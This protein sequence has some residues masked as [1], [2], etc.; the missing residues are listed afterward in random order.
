MTSSLP[1]PTIL[2]PT[3]P[4]T[5]SSDTKHQPFGLKPL[6]HTHTDLAAEGC[7]DVDEWEAGIGPI[8]GDWVDEVRARMLGVR[9]LGVRNA[10]CQM[11]ECLV[12]ECLVYQ[13]RGVSECLVPECLVPEWL[14]PEWPPWL[15]AQLVMDGE[16]QAE[17]THPPPT[18]DIGSGLA[19]L[20][21]VHQAAAGWWGVPGCGGGGRTHRPVARL[22]GGRG[23][24]TNT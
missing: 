22:G 19:G 24:H 17:S 21:R 8:L 15:V 13:N 11:S 10:W 23:P 5:N 18:H 2:T 16:T 1:A 9:M 14:V 12:S 3:M 7:F 20:C 4:D 6:I